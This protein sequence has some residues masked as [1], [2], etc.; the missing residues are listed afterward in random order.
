MNE[1]RPPDFLVHDEHDDVGVVVVEHVESGQALS[2]WSMETDET[3]EITTLESI[4]LGHKIAL[5]DIS[6]GDDVIEYGEVIGRASADIARGSHLHI[7]NTK[8]KK[9]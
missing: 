9:W 6:Q 7:H 1:A 5:K 2:G 4:P 3:L 8:T